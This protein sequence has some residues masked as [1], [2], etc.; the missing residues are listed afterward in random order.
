[1]DH[2]FPMLVVELIDYYRFQANLTQLNLEY[3]LN[4]GYRCGQKCYLGYNWRPTYYQHLYTDIFNKYHERVAKL[5]DNYV[6]TYDIGV[7]KNVI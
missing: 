4:I 1:M 2:V 5:P 6:L 3:Q 7:V